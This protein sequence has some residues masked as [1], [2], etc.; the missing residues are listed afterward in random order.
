[1][2][3]R[4][5]GRSNCC[6]QCCFK[7]FAFVLSVGF[8]VLIYWLASQPRYIKATISSAQLANLT[9]T[10]ATA[11]S[12]TLGVTLRLY[13]PSLRVKI[14]YDSLDTE[15][16]FR[17]ELLGHASTTSPAEFYQRQKRS[18]NVSVN[19]SGTGVVVSGDAAAEL[20]KEKGEGKVSLE[21]AVDARV[22]YKFF[23]FGTIKIRQKPRI[24][25]SVAIPVKADGGG[26][27]SSGD[28]CSVKY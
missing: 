3:S 18:D 14:Y 25:C 8:V 23:F 24:R 19:L 20:E 2:A 28:R 26:V 12:Y 4:V 5:Q 7:L 17:G 10:N 22:R 11:V 1:M 27:L 13:N 9:V 6:C 21:L 16:R 15:L